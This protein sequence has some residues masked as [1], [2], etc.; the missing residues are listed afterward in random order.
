MGESSQTCPNGQC[1]ALIPAGLDFCT[2]CGTLIR[3]AAPLDPPP[4]P[5]GKRGRTQLG[6]G[7]SMLLVA[8]AAILIYTSLNPPNANRAEDSFQ[9]AMRAGQASPSQATAEQS[10]EQPRE[11]QPEQESGPVAADIRSGSPSDLA[12][13][14]SATCQGDPTF[15]QDGD[16]YIPFQTTSAQAVDGDLQSFW[17]CAKK[18]GGWFSR[19]AKK[20]PKAVGQQLR[21]ELSTPSV[22]SEIGIVNGWPEY[23]A[24]AREGLGA[25]RYNEN[26]RVTGVRVLLNY[27][28]VQV[29]DAVA[30]LEDLDQQPPE[31][32]SYID[33]DTWMQW[34]SLDDSVV[35]DEVILE[36]ADIAAGTSPKLQKTAAIAE[37]QLRGWES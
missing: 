31:F 26:G 2:S 28:G 7:L 29:A 21:L 17:R 32:G 34:V 5:A 35:V 22:L 11:A 16:D 27:E 18:V 25:D 12:V 36:I 8:V 14:A 30:S 19:Y 9:R 3:S 33:A 24:D 13:Q 20:Q 6:I 1:L 23:Q 37:V 10:A 15:R 4:V